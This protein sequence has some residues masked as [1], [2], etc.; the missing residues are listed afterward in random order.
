MNALRLGSGRSRTTVLAL[1]GL[2]LL[3][4]LAPAASMAGKKAKKKDP[5][6]KVMTRNLYLGADL[7]PAISAPDT[8]A[9]IDAG[10]EILN[11]VDAS[12]FPERAKLLAAEI[13]KAKPDLLGLQEVAL[14]RF[15]ENAD[16]TASAATEVRYDFLALPEGAQGEERQLQGRGR[17]GG[18]R[19]GAARRS[20]R[21]RR[22]LRP[23]LPALRRR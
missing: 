9:A 14:W 15:Q 11:D 21:L 13:A 22:H 17:A 10:G 2:A 19:P 20:R 3:A 16:F 12:N 18:V 7:G 4:L 1:F 6:V 23:E 8:C 5:T